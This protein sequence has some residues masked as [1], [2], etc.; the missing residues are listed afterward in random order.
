MNLKYKK[1]KKKKKKSLKNASYSKNWSILTY[2]T[3]CLV[4]Q[5]TFKNLLVLLYV[6]YH[7]FINV[8]NG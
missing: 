5:T 8:F 4:L 2:D 1:K 3:R 7:D 6:F